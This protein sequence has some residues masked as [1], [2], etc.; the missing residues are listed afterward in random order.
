M[1]VFTVAIFKNG[2]TESKSFHCYTQAEDYF[3]GVE[4]T[5]DFDILTLMNSFGKTIKQVTTL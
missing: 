1:M 5:K 2:T 3:A 4:M